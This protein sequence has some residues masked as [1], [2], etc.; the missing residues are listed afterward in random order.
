MGLFVKTAGKVD[1]NI[2]ADLEMEHL[3]RRIKKPFKA[4]GPNNLEGSVV[5]KS[6]QHK[7]AV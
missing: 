5:K 3:V 7:N 6:I 4:T 2:P 1:S